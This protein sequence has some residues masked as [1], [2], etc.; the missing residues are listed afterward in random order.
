MV[1]RSERGGA[2]S[3]GQRSEGRRTR[4]HKMGQTKFSKIIFYKGFSLPRQY[5]YNTNTD[6]HK[7][8][9]NTDTT[10]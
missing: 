5:K 8:N 3:T 9:Y 10:K 2:S 4:Y 6:I 7:N 1:S